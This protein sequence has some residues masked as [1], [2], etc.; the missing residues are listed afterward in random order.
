MQAA[1]DIP[2][3]DEELVCTD[4]CS[5]CDMEPTAKMRHQTKMDI[6]RPM[7]FAIGAATRASISVSLAYPLATTAAEFVP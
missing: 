2:K 6:I 5:G 3:V 7:Q 1:R 4:Q